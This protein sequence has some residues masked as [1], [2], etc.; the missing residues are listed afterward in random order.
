MSSFRNNGSIAIRNVLSTGRDGAI[1]SESAESA[2]AG[3]AARLLESPAVCQADD[4]DGEFAI[5]IFLPPNE[6][7][8]LD[9]ADGIGSA[10]G[11]GSLAPGD[12]FA[13][14]NC[15]DILDSACQWRRYTACSK[16]NPAAIFVDS[17]YG[18]KGET[19]TTVIQ[20]SKGTVHYKSQ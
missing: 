2:A 6:K 17:L 5:C 14:R 7:D 4:T 8:A 3:I 13:T 16:D 20:W 10:G 12:V 19:P 18:S 9:S 15:A 11:G 1:D